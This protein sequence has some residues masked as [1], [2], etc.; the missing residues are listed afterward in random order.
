ML[1]RISVDIR[2]CLRVVGFSRSSQVT[3]FL[4]SDDDAREGREAGF[5]IMAGAAN[6]AEGGKEPVV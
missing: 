3:V 5:V 4:H 6:L 2:V 1:P